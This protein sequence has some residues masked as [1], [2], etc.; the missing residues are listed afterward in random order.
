MLRRL[1][2]LLPLAL[3]P[4]LAGAA[5]GVHAEPGLNLVLY[6]AVILLLAKAGG[7][8]AVRMDQPA[9]LGELLVGIA[10]GNMALPL[11]ERMR[12]NVDLEML[13]RLGV[14]VLLFEV[15]LE[16]TVG[17]FLK[18]GWASL[19][20]AVIGVVL[21]FFL[22]WGL[23]AL[24][25]PGE[26]VFVHVFLGAA[27]CATSVGITARVLGDL[28]AAR[29]QE[30]RVILGAAVI[31]DVLGL[32]V[33]AVVSSLI[34]AVGSGEALSAVAFIPLLLKAVAFLVLSLSLGV[35]FAP[36]VFHAAAAL[37]VQGMQLALGLIF[38][39]G[40][41]WVA[42]A[43]GLAPL[44]GAF[45]AGLILEEAHYE[46][47]LAKGEQGLS[48]Y[49]HPI[50]GFLVP[51][52]FVMMGLRTDLGSLLRPGMLRLSLGL[53]AV[54]ILGKLV[55]GL[56]APRGSDR[57]SVG[58]GMVPRG[59]VGLIFANVGAALTLGGRPV[60]SAD[61][62]AAIVAMVVLTTMITPPALRWSLR[63]PG[64]AAHKG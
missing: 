51:V 40:L 19:R 12:A 3:L 15:G 48:R 41:S 37:K 28:H 13:A 47:F 17:Q 18:V 52:F 30:A 50:S 10:M 34:A 55:A 6:L 14:L 27:L 58:L 45:T 33:L 56:G 22:G 60:V 11:F 62:Y 44:V 32:L 25:L 26:S 38:C 5:D 61:H 4:A 31:D 7:E 16:S 20:V 42:G 21:P 9:V 57:L 59:E 63:R 49:I 43:I 2:I 29:S 53:T 1:L 46:K 39:F 35:R 8:V 24:L 36:A 64:G 54:A 23:G